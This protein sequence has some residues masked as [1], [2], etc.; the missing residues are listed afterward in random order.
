MRWGGERPSLHFYWLK[1]IFNLQHHIGMI[2][3]ELA[4]DDAVSLYSEEMDCC[5]AKCYGSDM[6]R[7]DVTKVTNTV[8]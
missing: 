4:L 3:E 5:T 1:T 6:I 8:P 7:T 2:W